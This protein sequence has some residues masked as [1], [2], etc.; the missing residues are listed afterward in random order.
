MKKKKQFL[1]LLYAL[2]NAS[3]SD[4]F[5]WF[6]CF[7]D[8]EEKLTQSDIEDLL[9]QWGLG[10]I[11]YY[12]SSS[13]YEERRFIPSYFLNILRKRYK[14]KIPLEEKQVESFFKNLLISNIKLLERCSKETIPVLENRMGRITQISPLIV[15]SSKSYF[16]IS[17]FALEK[18]KELIKA[19]K[20][21]LT[22]KWKEK[23]SDI[24]NFF[25]EENYP[26]VDLRSIFDIEGAYCWEVKYVETPEKTPISVSILLS[27]YI[28]PLDR[29]SDILGEMRRMSSSPLNLIF[30]LK[31]TLPA[32][33]NALSH[34]ASQ[35]Y[36]IFLFEEKS[37]KFYVIERGTLLE[38]TSF[39]VDSFLSKFLPFL[40]KQIQIGRTFPDYLENYME[41]LKLF[42]KFPRLV[43]ARNHLLKVEPKLRESIRSKL[44]E[45]LGTLWKDKIME[46]N[47]SL[48]KKCE[49]VI[50][51]RL[52]KEKAKDFL[53][54]ATLGELIGIAENFPNIFDVNKDIIKGFLNILNQHR[55]V[56]EHPFE[57]PKEDLDEKTF[58]SLTAALEYIE[59]VIC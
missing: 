38:E 37:Q 4:L 44:R 14:E 50:K 25:T 3:V 17:P 7:F 12:R 2:S 41:N 52:D 34:I 19:K 11:L 57:E 22:K 56:L 15:E 30:L 1:F 26:F 24:L 16:G 46:M 10:N 40:E 33:T 39:A 28:F 49:N 18:I 58:K 23:F 29:Y 53:D 51:K 55:K 45:N 32:I 27:P 6:V 9:V 59:S 35:K 13:G 8:K 43:S 20:Q 48:V 31:E 5:R 21:D 42:N 54:G 47:P 36:L